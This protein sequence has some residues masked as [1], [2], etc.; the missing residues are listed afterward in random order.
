MNDHIPLLG[1]GYFLAGTNSFVYAYRAGDNEL[2]DE[3]INEAPG[4]TPL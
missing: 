4:R 3:H 1:N 2:L